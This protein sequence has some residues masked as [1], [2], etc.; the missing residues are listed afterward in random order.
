MDLGARWRQVVS[1]RSHLF[2]PFYRSWWTAYLVWTLTCRNKSLIYAGI[3]LRFLGHLACCPAYIIPLLFTLCNDTHVSSSND[4]SCIV[5]NCHC[6]VV[7]TCGNSIKNDFSK[8]DIIHPLQLW[9]MLTNV[10]SHF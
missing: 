3:E 9:N 1:F 5:L 10:N 7:R 2:I 6:H 4:F 8:K